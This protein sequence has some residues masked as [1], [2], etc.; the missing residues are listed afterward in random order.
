MCGIAMNSKDS[1]KREEEYR[2][3]DDLRTLSRAEE[4]RSDPKRVAACRRV[5]RKQARATSRMGRALKR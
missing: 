3:E 2:A 4:I 1:K 5:N